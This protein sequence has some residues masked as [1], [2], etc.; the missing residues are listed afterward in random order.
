MG[1]GEDLYNSAEVSATDPLADL[2]QIDKIT[3]TGK[4]MMDLGS[5]ILHLR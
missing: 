1:T 3:F 2:I 5:W 4:A